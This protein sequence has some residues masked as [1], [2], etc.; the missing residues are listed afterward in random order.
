MGRSQRRKRQT[1]G[2]LQ[3]SGSKRMKWKPV[4]PRS[5]TRLVSRPC[6]NMSATDH[7]PMLLDNTLRSKTLRFGKCSNASLRRRLEG[8]PQMSVAQAPLDDVGPPNMGS[9]R[10][11]QRSRFRRPFHPCLRGFYDVNSFA[12]TR[13]WQSHSPQT[14][15]SGSTGRQHFRTVRAHLE[16][17]GSDRS[18]PSQS[19][20]VF[21]CLPWPTFEK[22]SSLVGLRCAVELV[23]LERAVVRIADSELAC[24]LKCALAC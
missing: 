14:L 20:P 13:S 17:D 22:R 24:Q 18:R 8:G 2:H 3:R 4:S 16:P 9:N 23:R 10:T 21:A 7:T 15:E 19:F 11:H 1:W 6:A 5:A 12:A